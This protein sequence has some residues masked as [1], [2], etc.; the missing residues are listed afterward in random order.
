MAPCKETNGYWEEETK[1]QMLAS[2]SSL[3]QSLQLLQILEGASLDDADL[4]V[5]QMQDSKILQASEVHF[6]DPGDVISVQVKALC[7]AGDAPRNGA[8]AQPVAVH[9]S[10]GADRRLA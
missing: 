4:I 6:G 10:G 3:E 8:Q 5:F 2:A 9:A 7:V 1:P